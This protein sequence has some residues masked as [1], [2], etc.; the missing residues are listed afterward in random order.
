MATLI[1]TINSELMQRKD[2]D[3]LD[4]LI[5]SYIA[6]WES[7]GSVCF[8]KDG[9]FEILLGVTRDEVTFSLIKLEER[10]LIKQIRGTGGRV[11]KTA[12]AIPD[13]VECTVGDIFEI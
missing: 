11:L 9:F 10:G 8:A 5:V 2:M 3:L 6:N 4:K 1:L 12:K 13:R 7:R